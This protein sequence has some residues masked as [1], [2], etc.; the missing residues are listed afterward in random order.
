MG[1]LHMTYSDAIRIRLQD[2]CDKRNITVNRLASLS[3]LTQSTIEYIMNGKSK[4]PSLITLHKIA[5]GLNM[6]ISE[7]LD[8]PELNDE[9]LYK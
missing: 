2:L 7:L 6:T 4:N 3:G 8:F 1:V 9:D 5:T